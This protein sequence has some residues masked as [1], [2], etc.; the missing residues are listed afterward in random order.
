MVFKITHLRPINYMKKSTSDRKNF[1]MEFLVIEKSWYLKLPWV[2]CANAH[3]QT[4]IGNCRWKYCSY[5]YSE[6]PNYFDQLQIIPNN[7]QQFLTILNNSKQFQTIPN[8]FI[9]FA[10]SYTIKGKTKSVC[11]L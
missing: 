9:E 7:S 8:S 1:E 6:V 4:N 2:K 5:A 11:L 3:G 10:Q